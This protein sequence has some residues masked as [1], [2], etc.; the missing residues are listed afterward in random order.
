MSKIVR[1]E[2]ALTLE[3][4]CPSDAIAAAKAAGS[5]A[6]HKTPEL[7][8]YCQG[9]HPIK[10]EI[11]IVATAGEIRINATVE[12]E[13]GG[14]AQA[15]TAAAVAAVTLTEMTGASLQTVTLAAMEAPAPKPYAR[16]VPVTR[17]V[18]SA[19]AP[20][21]LMGLIS[22]PP[23]SE[24]KGDKREAF[25]AFMTARHLRISDWAKQAGVP[26]AIV[27]AFLTGRTSSLASD[28]AEKLAAAANVKPEDLFR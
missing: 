25:R 26:A 8:P 19:P 18:K 10:T 15:L 4:E 20:T 17:A 7:I 14:E 5:L 22:A 1:A 11:D 12:V 6:A 2:A 16:K 3:G 21:T 9:V 23:P 27:Y 28:V 13:T 24:G